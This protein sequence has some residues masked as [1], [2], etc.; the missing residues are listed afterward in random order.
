VQA[1]REPDI[2]ERG[3]RFAVMFRDPVTEAAAV[4]VVS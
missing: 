1:W 2:I 4:A 3:W